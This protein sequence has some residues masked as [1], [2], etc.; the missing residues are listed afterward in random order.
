MLSIWQIFF[1]MT[2]S[3]QA[4]YRPNRYAICAILRGDDYN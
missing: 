4:I 1:A 2:T 3:V